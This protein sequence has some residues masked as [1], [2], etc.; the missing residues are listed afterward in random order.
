MDTTSLSG[1][2]PFQFETEKLKRAERL[3]HLAKAKIANTLSGVHTESLQRFIA[4]NLVMN[5]VE[6]PSGSTSSHELR[7]LRLAVSAGLGHYAATKPSAR[8]EQWVSFLVDLALRRS[9]PIFAHEILKWHACL[10]ECGLKPGE[11]RRRVGSANSRTGSLSAG[12]SDHEP[13]EGLADLVAWLNGSS[14]HIEQG[15]SRLSPLV[16]AGIAHFWIKNSRALGRSHSDLAS[17]VSAAILAEEGANRVITGLSSTLRRYP[18][19]YAEMLQPSRENDITQWLL[20]FAAKGVEAQ[21]RQFAQLEF[22]ISTDRLIEQAYIDLNARQHALLS[23]LREGGPDGFPRGITAS[24]HMRITDTS[25]ATATRDLFALV[26]IGILIKRGENKWRRYFL[27]V[28]KDPIP[29]MT[30][31][32]V[33]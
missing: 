9:E 33:L 28:P 27:N 6:A 25:I 11:G 19:E 21:K 1:T 26:E 12:I 16:K 15:P 2:L 5:V 7:T 4:W 23:D 30:I 8:H 22:L 3:F 20:W 31:E 14:S 17:G 18:Q 29:V 10:T 13:A 32:M 24:D